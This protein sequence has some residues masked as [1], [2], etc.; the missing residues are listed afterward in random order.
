[1]F[2]FQVLR[3]AFMTNAF[4]WMHFWIANSVLDLK[5]QKM[6]INCFSDEFLRYFSILRFILNLLVLAPISLF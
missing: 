5:I 6:H 3:I 4:L 1:M 2:F